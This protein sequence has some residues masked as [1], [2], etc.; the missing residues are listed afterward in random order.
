[1]AAD[2]D[3]FLLFIL[4][5]GDDKLLSVNK[6]ILAWLNKNIDIIN[7]AGIKIGVKGISVDDAKKQNVR[8]LLQEKYGIANLPALFDTKDKSTKVGYKEIKQVLAGILKR[9]VEEQV[10][11]AAPTTD[12]QEF[13]AR[14]LNMDRFQATQ[15]NDENVPSDESISNDT[16][17]QKNLRNFDEHRKASMKKGKNVQN[18][19][20]AGSIDEMDV[21]NARR[22]GTAAPAPT[23]AASSRQTGAARA[24]TQTGPKP[25]SPATRAGGGGDPDDLMMA[26]WEANNSDLLGH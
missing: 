7:Q 6:G 17:F 16:N 20:T 19:Y 18:K 25:I 26:A 1:M 12:I 14:D 13:W 5:D 24:S 15:G 23:P 11:V 22:P 21:S 9:Q 2:Q 3:L 8:T 4:K 10:S